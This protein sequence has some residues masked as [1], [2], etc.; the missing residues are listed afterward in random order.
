[1]NIRIQ[2]NT[3]F[4]T[5][6]LLGALL[7]SS[8]AGTATKANF[9]NGSSMTALVSSKDGVKA[10]VKA[11][12][13]IS[14][15]EVEKTRIAQRIEERTAAKKTHNASGAENKN[16]DVELT[17]TRYEKGN[18]FAR[19]MLAGLGQI[20]IDGIVRMYELPNKKKVGE[21]TIKKTFA[22]GGLYGGTTSM[23]DI[24]RTFAD[25]IAATITGQKEDAP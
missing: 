8:C 5:F 7:F 10:R 21:F 23:E 6:G 16:Y 19:S 20:H 3:T 2:Y 17:L 22:W 11:D 25:S 1:M 9:K 12:S 15:L 4:I 18:A 14:I 13:N 24:E